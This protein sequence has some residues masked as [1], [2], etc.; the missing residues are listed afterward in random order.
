MA[1]TPKQQIFVD[2]Y[3]NGAHLNA[4]E[5]ARLAGYKHP[6]Q[7]GPRQLRK[8]HV[9]E[10]INDYL[11]TVALTTAEAVEE[12][13]KMVRNPV[14][15]RLSAAN[16]IRAIEVFLRYQGELKDQVTGELTLKIDRTDNSNLTKP[17]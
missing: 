8:V 6:N 14:S 5:A 9:R 12:L 10:A 11:Q 13:A 15:T 2:Y 3:L 17:T 1:L 4:S 16:K 7:L